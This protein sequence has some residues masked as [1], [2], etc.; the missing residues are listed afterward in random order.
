MASPLLVLIFSRFF[1]WVKAEDD[2]RR[3]KYLAFIEIAAVYTGACRS[4]LYEFAKQN[5]G[6]LLPGVQAIEDTART[7]LGPIWDEYQYV[8]VELLRFIDRKV[9]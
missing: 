3:L 1:L 2:D 4:S 8:P 9:S 6:P 5:A 7:V